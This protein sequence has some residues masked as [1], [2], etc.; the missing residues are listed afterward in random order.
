[1]ANVKKFNKINMGHMLRHYAR[2]PGEIVKRNNER[3]DPDR[4]HLNYNLAADLQKLPQ[5]EFVKK[6]LSEVSH[7]D[8]DKKK[9]LVLLCDFVITLP[10]NVPQERSGEFFQAVYDFCCKRYGAENVIS[11]YVHRDETR[12]H[13]HFAFIPVVKD[14]DGNERLCA[15]QCVSRLVLE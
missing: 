7:Y 15:K 2:Q 6:R 14:A 13:M 1:M 11:A 8:L 5:N 12:D 4:T 9:D 3:I 10:E